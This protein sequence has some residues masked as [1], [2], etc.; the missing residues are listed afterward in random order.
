M[1]PREKLR[2][3]GVPV[4]PLRQTLGCATTEGGRVWNTAAA[5]TW[6]ELY[7]SAWPTDAETVHFE[8]ENVRR[9]AKSAKAHVPPRLGAGER[10]MRRLGNV[11]VR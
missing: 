1:M 2:A 10:V 9:R 8:R 7:S 6:L 4:S 5:S 11:E 3:T